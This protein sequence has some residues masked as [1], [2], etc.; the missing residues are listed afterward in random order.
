MTLIALRS[1]PCSPWIVASDVIAEVQSVKPTLS[2]DESTA[3]DIAAAV[4]ELLYKFS[5]EQFTGECGP[6]TV[7]PVARPTDMDTRGLANLFGSSG[8]MGSWGVCTSYGQAATGVAAHYGCSKP[9]Q[10][11]LGAYPVTEIVEVL[12]DGVTIPA[13]EYYLQ[14]F[15]VLVR[16]R[17]TAQSDPTERWGWPTCQLLDLPDTQPG[18]FSVTFNYGQPPPQAGIE[19][20]KALARAMG[21]QALNQPND[22]PTRTTSITRQGVAMAVLD[23]MDFVQQGRTGI[24]LVDIF[25]KAYNPTGQ[26]RPALVWSPDTG[27]PRRA[28]G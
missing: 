19:A 25:I 2:L 21:L 9:P 17:P 18:T 13:N 12:I 4:S 7:R 5:G 20:A 11:E 24:Y 3:S 10:I 27:R 16:E 15:K 1:G 8:Y 26:T 14:D 28:P 6:I 23:V 22:L